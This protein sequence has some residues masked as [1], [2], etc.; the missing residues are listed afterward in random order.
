MENTHTKSNH[1]QYVLPWEASYTETKA[2]LLQKTAEIGLKY[3]ELVHLML[4]SQ[5][6]F[7]F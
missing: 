4:F 7:V 1:K 3:A 5:C 6:S 2:L